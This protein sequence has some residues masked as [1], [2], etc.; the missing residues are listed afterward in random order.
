M[1]TLSLLE[2]FWYAG[3][4]F[5]I[6]RLCKEL[7]IFAMSYCI[8]LRHKNSTFIAIVHEKDNIYIKIVIL[9]LC[10]SLPWTT[11]VHSISFQD[12]MLMHKYFFFKYKN[13]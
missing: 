8:Q 1:V 10:D 6:R 7:E 4:L 11:M 12:L 13:K 5:L 2:L 9:I 3:I